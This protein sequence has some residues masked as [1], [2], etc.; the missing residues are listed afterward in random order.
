MIH[1]VFDFANF[2]DWAALSIKDSDEKVMLTS[3]LYVIK[4]VSCE[5]FSLSLVLCEALPA[6]NTMKRDWC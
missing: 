2:R 6:E 4:H 3:N 1:F 5:D